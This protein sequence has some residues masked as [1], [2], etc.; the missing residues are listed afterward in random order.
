MR[1]L[2]RGLSTRSLASCMLRGGHGIAPPNSVKV[3]IALEALGLNF[4][5]GEQKGAAFVLH[6]RLAP[7]R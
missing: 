3:P 2:L 5:Q 4:R 6:P 1:S 7:P